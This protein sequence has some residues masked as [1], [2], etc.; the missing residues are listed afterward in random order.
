M[1]LYEYVCAVCGRT[2][3]RLLP[4]NS[5]APLCCGQAM[6]RQWGGGHLI[7]KMKFP[8]WVEKMDDIHK[9][10]EQRGER[11][12]LVQPWEVGAS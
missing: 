8:L 11:L 10:Q 12:R 5:P 7:I 1:P 3:E 2:A 6:T 9:A 4:M